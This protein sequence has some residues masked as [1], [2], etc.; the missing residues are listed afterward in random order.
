M[1]ISIETPNITSSNFSTPEKVR[2]STTERTDDKVEFGIFIYRCPRTQDRVKSGIE[3]DYRTF[4]KIGKLHLRVSC[5]ACQNTHL[6]KMEGGE[7]SATR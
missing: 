2:A 7:L 6:I 5:D 3:M 4:R 1:N